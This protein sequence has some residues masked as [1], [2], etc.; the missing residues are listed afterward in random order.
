MEW[1]IR[2]WK[3]HVRE[4]HQFVTPM[5]RTLGRAERRVA[6]TRYVQGLLLPGQRKSVEPMADRMQ[7]DPQ[8]LTHKAREMISAK[9]VIICPLKDLIMRR[10]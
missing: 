4:F 7:V 2:H 3:N 9:R 1:N 8:P 10:S 5:V 6:A